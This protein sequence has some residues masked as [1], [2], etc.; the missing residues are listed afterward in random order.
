MPT[1]NI[2]HTSVLS[3]LLL[4]AACTEGK[5]EL[6][7]EPTSDEREA[8]TFEDENGVPRDLL[9]G[10]TASIAE[11]DTED[12]AIYLHRM[13]YD[14]N[15]YL[16]SESYED[17][18]GEWVTF[19]Q[20][21]TRLDD[22]GRPETLIEDETWDIWT[23]TLTYDAD[24]WRIVKTTRL[25]E[26]V[27]EGESNV[28]EVARVWDAEGW[29]E[30]AYGCTERAVLGEGLRIAEKTTTCG[31]SEPDTELY[32]WEG[33][34]LRHLEIADGEWALDADFQYDGGRLSRVDISG[35]F[36]ASTTYTWDCPL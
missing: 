36:S 20:Y 19:L 35:F 12:G 9:A 11:E 14:D 25:H 29:T 24:S 10:C 33:D 4:G 22:L 17:I 28:S 8:G 34:R 32:T 26:L 27:K 13:T 18:S 31:D 21:E 30:E 7:T 15:G 23:H 16:M 3:L 2:T 1:T 5:P 6:E